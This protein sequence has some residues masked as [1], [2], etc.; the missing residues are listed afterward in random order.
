MG[1]H[2]EC[3]GK[4][5]SDLDPV[6]TARTC[7][8]GREMMCLAPP[9]AQGRLGEGC[10]GRADT[11]P[12]KGRSPLAPQSRF[13]KQE[14]LFVPQVENDPADHGSGCKASD[15]ALFLERADSSAES[16][17]PLAGRGKLNLKMR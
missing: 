6:P 16:L 17:S 5:G 3:L 1:G 15:T 14:G 2:C 9:A 8:R 7:T 11:S 10:G 13:P 4:P 12:I